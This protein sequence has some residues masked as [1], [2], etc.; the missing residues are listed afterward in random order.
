MSERR[1]LLDSHTVYWALDDMPELSRRAREL[2]TSDATDVFVSALSFYELMF[3][4][5]RG[6]LAGALLRVG[7]AARAAGFRTVSPT[8]HDWK[9]AAVRNWSHGDPFD[10]LLLA[11]AESGNMVLVS[12]DAVFDEVSDVRVW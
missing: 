4:A 6:R 1:L 5:N 7:D 2:I 11:Q 3:K 10:R 12:K 9:A 8:E